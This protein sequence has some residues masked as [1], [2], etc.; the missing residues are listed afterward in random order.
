MQLLTQ[1]NVQQIWNH[2]ASHVFVR[3]NFQT[4]D[5]GGNGGL[6]L[7]SRVGLYA[8]IQ[9]HLPLSVLVVKCQPKP[10]TR[11]KESTPTQNY[12]VGF[13]ARNQLGLTSS[14]CVGGSNKAWLEP[15]HE[16]F[17]NLV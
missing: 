10:Y 4:N 14:C 8:L 3:F 11:G 16:P 5:E 9:P 15:E 12:Q 6:W 17:I 7:G 2:P 1:E 13:I